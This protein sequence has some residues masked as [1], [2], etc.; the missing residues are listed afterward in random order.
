MNSIPIIKGGGCSNSEGEVCD[1][2]FR[3]GDVEGGSSTGMYIK[4]T[5]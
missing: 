1:G 4:T 2:E 3:G 5:R